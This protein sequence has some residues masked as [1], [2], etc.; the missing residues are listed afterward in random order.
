[1]SG[2]STALAAEAVSLIGKE[3][4]AKRKLISIG[5][6]ILWTPELDTLKIQVSVIKISNLAVFH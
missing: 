2:F 3:T 5:W 4:S 6:P 1:V